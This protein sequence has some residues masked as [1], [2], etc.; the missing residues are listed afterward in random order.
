ML[1]WSD[2]KTEPRSNR[3]HYASRFAK[4]MPVFFVQ[5]WSSRL[6]ETRTEETEIPN[7]EIVHTSNDFGERQAAEIT[8][9]LAKR[10][11]RKP[12]LWIYNTDNF[13]PLIDRLPNALRIYHA[14]E[15]YLTPTRE[16]PKPNRRI[17]DSVLRVLPQVDLLVGVSQKVIDAYRLHGGYLGPAVLAENGCDS[18]FFLDILDKH[19]SIPEKPIAIYQGNINFRLDF[20]LLNAVVSAMPEWE[21]WFCGKEVVTPSD[22]QTLKAQ[23]NVRYLGNLTPEEF[24]KRMCEASVGLIP[25]KQEEAIYNSL[26]LKAYE[27]VACGLP[28]VSVPIEALQRD[29][30]LFAIA[31]TPK[32]FAEQLRLALPKRDDE[33]LLQARREAA[34]HHSYDA[35]YQ[36][37]CHAIAHEY[38]KLLARPRRLNIAVIYDDRSTHINTVAEHL[39][40]FRKYSRHQIF[41]V[42]GISNKYL[43]A[44]LRFDNDASQYANL[45]MYDAIILHYSVRMSLTN[46][47]SPIA[48]SMLEKAPGLKILFIQDEYE[49]TSNAQNWIERLRFDI[50]Y[51]CVPPEGREYVYPSARM[52]KTEFLPTLTGYIPEDP[53]IDNYVIPIEERRTRIGYRGRMLHYFYGMLAHEKYLI[54]VHMKKICEDAGVPAD[55]EVDDTLRIYGPDWYRFL[56]SARA[57]LGTESGS[58]VFDFD[59]SLRSGIDEALKKEPH[60]TFYDIHARLLAEHE[61]RVRMNQI[62]PKIF[63]AIRL[64]TALVLFEG[65][66]SGV[67]QKD[68]HYIPLKHDFSNAAEVLAKLEDI[69]YLKELTERAYTDVIESGRYSYKSFVESVDADILARVP[70]G[71]RYEVYATPVLYRSRQGGVI[72]A[73][74][75]RGMGYSLSTGLLDGRMRREELSGALQPMLTSIRNDRF[76]NASLSRRIFI[77]FP[78]RITGRILRLT[79]ALLRRLPLPAKI[80]IYRAYNILSDACD[81]LKRMLMTPIKRALYAIRNAIL[82]ACQ[83]LYRYV[84]RNHGGFL[85][86]MMRFVVEHMPAS[87]RY[88]LWRMCQS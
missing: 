79:Y 73:L 15:D 83:K 33:Q 7:L 26:P 21:F 66:Y 53:H 42:P 49:M 85:Y 48:A 54:G 58:N 71:A 17:L 12:L 1:T 19:P 2:W 28:V 77:G 34:Q 52:G 64:R 5:P 81:W 88:R 62:S 35:R 76:K 55:I 29:P 22:W 84:S 41:Y 10:G 6:A 20:P 86:R 65:E 43:G 38:E 80:M 39:D 74:P 18:G 75:G 46:H 23:P 59:G 78:T 87:L 25:F 67:V 27:Y 63:E 57:T 72:D 8:E 47:I 4:E 70:H 24:G 69:D 30:E 16:L 68:L 82:H 51:T 13:Q 45:E 44:D 3:Y 11:I 14:T 40:A 36:D 31:E 61:G 56:G 50:V 32:Q 60:L 9:I 37:V